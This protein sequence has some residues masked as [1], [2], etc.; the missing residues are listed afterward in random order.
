MGVRSN[1][2]IIIIGSFSLLGSPDKCLQRGTGILNC[3]VFTA[4]FFFLFLSQ[5]TIF[6][7]GTRRMVLRAALWMC[8]EG[9]AM[10]LGI[11]RGRELPVGT[12]SRFPTRTWRIHWDTEVS[13]AG[14]LGP[15]PPCC[16][17][18]Y[19]LPHLHWRPCSHIC[20]ARSQHNV[21]TSNSRA[22]I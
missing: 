12:C 19:L 2:S 22:Y 17:G 11:D 5:V 13:R 15:S 10:G 7:S 18:C 16:R 6:S 4:E 8:S 3:S 9:S 20:E 1:P 14:F 21:I